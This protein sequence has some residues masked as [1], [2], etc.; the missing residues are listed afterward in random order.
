MP[1]ATTPVTTPSGPAGATAL[2]SPTPDV[3]TTDSVPAELA[4]AILRVARE[5]EPRSLAVSGLP[6][7]TGTEATVMRWVHRNPGCTPTEVAEAT[8]LQRSNISTALRSLTAKALVE[9]R[10]RGTDSRQVS[11]D[12]TDTARAGI[13]MLYATWSEIVG[14][15]LG[16]RS[17][18]AGAALA[19]LEL[20]EDHLRRSR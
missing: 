20:V 16:E 7:L 15:A 6:P 8:G 12:V 4:D 14:E 17:G 1:D 3:G 5:L 19:V 13:A 9:R 10:R 11:L 2:G 18:Q